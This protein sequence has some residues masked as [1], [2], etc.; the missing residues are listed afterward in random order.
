MNNISRQLVI[1]EYLDTLGRQAL[2]ARQDLQGLTT[3]QKDQALKQIASA[4]VKEQDRLLVANAK[5]YQ[6]AKEAGMAESLLD[7]LQLTTARIESMAEG[8]RRLPPCRILSEKS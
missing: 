4:L 1:A 2:M 5:D 8:L 6:T 7:R 3:T